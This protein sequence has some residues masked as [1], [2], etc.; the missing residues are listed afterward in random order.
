MRYSLEPS[1]RKYVKGYGFLSFARNVGD[2]YGKKLM[3]NATKT[4]KDFAKTASKRAIKKTS[5]TTGDL[6]GNKIADKITSIGKPKKKKEKDEINEMEE[7][8]EI[9]IPPEK[10]KQIINDLRLFYISYK[11]GISKNY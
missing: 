11:N 6:I 10:R 2:K 3:D 1:Y 8:Q 7:T 4:G 9:Y 5:E